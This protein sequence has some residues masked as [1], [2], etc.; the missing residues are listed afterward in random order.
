VTT[1]PPAIQ[2]Q[3]FDTQ[4]KLR[5][6][7][8]SLSMSVLLEY[9]RKMSNTLDKSKK[10]PIIFLFL[11]IAVAI[12]FIRWVRAKLQLNYLNGSQFDVDILPND[13][14]GLFHKCLKSSKGW[15]LVYNICEYISFASLDNEIILATFSWSGNIPVSRDILTKCFNDSDHT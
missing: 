12:L 10:T 4:E 3:H 9:G 2:K 5:L 1:H 7:F 11:S 13:Y 14:T 8:H 15:K 6:N